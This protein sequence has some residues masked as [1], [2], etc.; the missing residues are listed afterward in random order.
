MDVLAM[1]MQTARG[2]GQF[3]ALAKHVFTTDSGVEE[4][5]VRQPGLKTLL[6]WFMDA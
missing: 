3:T 4:V 2:Y 5:L 6:N 1:E